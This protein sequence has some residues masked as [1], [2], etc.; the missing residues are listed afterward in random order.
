MFDVL[1]EEFV[2]FFYVFFCVPYRGERLVLLFVRASPLVLNFC[3]IRM[4]SLDAHYWL[5]SP[6]AKGLRN[7]TAAGNDSPLSHHT[8]THT[9]THTHTHRHTHTHTH[10]GRLRAREGE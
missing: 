2:L 4:V 3:T 9:D 5:N 10:R 8:D 1:N 6:S 7:L